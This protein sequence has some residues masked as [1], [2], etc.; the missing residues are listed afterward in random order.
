MYKKDKKKQSRIVHVVHLYTGLADVYLN[1]PGNYM[2]LHCIIKLYFTRSEAGGI[3][4]RITRD[5][6]P[7]IDDI[8]NKI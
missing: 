1:N 5:E 8:E 3:G 7:M 4:I 2:V 6:I